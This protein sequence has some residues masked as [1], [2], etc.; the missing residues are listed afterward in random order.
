MIDGAP[1]VDG[2]AHILFASR[3]FGGSVFD[4]AALVGVPITMVTYSRLI[5][6]A[7]LLSVH[8]AWQAD[9][10]G[11]AKADAARDHPDMYDMYFLVLM[12]ES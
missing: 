1:I 3:R 10:K 4:A 12:G 11:H 6:Y 7:A 2:N 9:D 8:H 5:E